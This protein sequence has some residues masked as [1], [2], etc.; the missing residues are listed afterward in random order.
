MGIAL[1]VVSVGSV[2]ASIPRHGKTAWFV[3]KPFLAPFMSILVVAGLTIGLLLI[4]AYFTTIDD[5]T[6]AG[7]VKKS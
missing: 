3:G 6:L 4:A 2:F 1:L 7:A 5:V